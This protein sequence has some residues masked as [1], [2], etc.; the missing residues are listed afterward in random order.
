MT[1]FTTEFDILE[2]GDIALMGVPLDENSSFLRGPA[3]AQSPKIQNGCAD[4]L[5]NQSKRSYPAVDCGNVE[6]DD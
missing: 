1:A 5:R 6:V 3:V 4:Q 2:L